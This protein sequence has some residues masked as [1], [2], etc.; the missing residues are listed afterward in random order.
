MILLLAILVGCAVG[1]LTGGRLWNL[2]RLRLKHAPA[3]IALFAVQALFRGSSLGSRWLSSSAALFVWSAC[4]AFLIALVMANRRVPGMPVVALGMFLNLLVV[5]VNAGMP[6]SGD[7]AAKIGAQ[8]SDIAGGLQGGFYELVTQSTHLA[9]LG[10]VI[11]VP[12]PQ[13]VRSVVSLGDLVMLLG[14]G[15]VVAIGMR[16]SVAPEGRSTSGSP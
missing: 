2:E 16:S 5:V 6:L 10:D 11:A 15:V 7:A 12:G 13:G 9:F 4:M 8:A 14:A 3:I 1:W